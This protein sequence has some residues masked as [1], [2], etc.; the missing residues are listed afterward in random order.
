ME[1]VD[2]ILEE[3]PFFKGMQQ[4]YRQAIS[5]CASNVRFHAGQYIF[6]E[7]E[8]ADKFYLLRQGCVALEVFVPGRGPISVETIKEGEI[9][10]WSWLIPPYKWSFDARALQLTQA[11]ALD[12]RCLRT[13]CEE[14]HGLG[15]E[16]LKRFAEVIA[17]RLKAT[18]FQILDIY[19]PYD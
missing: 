18:R 16:L 10:G 6:R 15:Y 1:I 8:S 13:K 11:I 3:H 7:G 12:G 17:H 2:R 9:L 4:A 19:G 14:D 5:A